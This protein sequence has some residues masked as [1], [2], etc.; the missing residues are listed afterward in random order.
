MSHNHGYRPQKFP[1][2]NTF[3]ER[4]DFS[5]LENDSA[6][7][8]PARGHGFPP[9]APGSDTAPKME[10]FPKTNTFPGQWNLSDLTE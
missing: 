6:Y 3:P 7:G 4:W 9:P 10:T 2:L 5:G 8:D 1:K